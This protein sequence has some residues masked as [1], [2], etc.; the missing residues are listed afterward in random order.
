MVARKRK[1]KSETPNQEE[2]KDDNADQTPA[3]PP[4]REL[5][6]ADLGPIG[7]TVAGCTEIVVT[8]A[9]DFCSGYLQGLLFGTL[10]GTPGFVFRPVTKGVRQPFSQELAGRFARMNGR[11]MNWA[12]KFGGI[13]AAF[14]GFGV[15]VKIIRNGEQDV[16]TDI[17]SS[18]A[19]GAYF[20]RNEGPQGMLRGALLYG[21]LIYCTSGSRRTPIQDYTEEP[22]TAVF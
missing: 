11:S 8:T 18:A 15:A 22:H 14:G 21:G 16:W 1:V 5:S 4:E 17:F 20:G 2:D 10:V 6:Y 19:A 9:L 3:G 13:S 12:K 7:K